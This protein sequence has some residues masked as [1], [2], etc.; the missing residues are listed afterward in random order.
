MQL[1]FTS[2]EVVENDV[3]HIPLQLKHFNLTQGGGADCSVCLLLCSE[4]YPPVCM[5]MSFMAIELYLCVYVTKGLGPVSAAG[6]LV[7]REH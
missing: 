5:C 6:P 4:Y 1:H 7:H 2:N 3:L